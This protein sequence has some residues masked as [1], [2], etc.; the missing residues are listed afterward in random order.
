MGKGVAVVLSND[1]EGS[2]RMPVLETSAICSF[3][4]IFCAM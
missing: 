1:A 3:C 4:L 2:V